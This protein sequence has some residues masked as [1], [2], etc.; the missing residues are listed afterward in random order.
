LSIH[1][2][3][4]RLR[5]Q[6]N[7]L[8]SDA[9]EMVLAEERARGAHSFAFYADFGH[10]VEG[11]RRDLT[12]LVDGLK[13]DG[14]TVAAYGA[15]AKGATLLNYTGIGTDRLDFVVDRNHHKQGRLMPGVGLRIEAPNRLTETMPD[16]VL[17]LAW[18]FADEI[19]AQQQAYL[20]AGGRF[21]LPVPSPR[22]VP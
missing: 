10:R 13:S 22:I 12:A 17:M 19:M 4:L 15:A 5:F 3:T 7:R 6:K 1:G 14:A 20:A 9:V 21:I 2:G 11:V 18:N 16:Y 8:P